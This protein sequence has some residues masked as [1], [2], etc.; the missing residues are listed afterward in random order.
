MRRQLNS[1]S[2]S[3]VN[4]ISSELVASS[5]TTNLYSISLIRFE[6]LE[7]TLVMFC[8]VQVCIITVNV[9]TICISKLFLYSSLLKPPIV[10]IIYHISLN[11][12]RTFYSFGCLQCPCTFLF[13][14]AVY[15]RAH[16]I[17]YAL[18][19]LYASGILHRL[20]SI[21]PHL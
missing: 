7:V 12:S 19:F 21:R 4:L 11:N 10:K 16:C 15:S 8:R 13:K 20:C 18:Y 3:I 17:F 9:N 1:S 2:S 14:G 6:L 5:I